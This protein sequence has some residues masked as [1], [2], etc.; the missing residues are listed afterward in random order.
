V[1]FLAVDF[2]PG[3]SRAMYNVTSDGQRFMMLRPVPAPPD[4][5]IL[6]QN[7]FRELE[8]RVGGN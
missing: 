2:V 6:V 4:R 5:L 8:E 1:L 3:G 7:F